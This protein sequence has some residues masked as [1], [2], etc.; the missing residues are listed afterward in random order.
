MKKSVMML[1]L[2]LLLIALSHPLVEGAIRVKVGC[3]VHY[4]VFKDS[5][6]KDIYGTGGIILG[7]FLAYE[8][9]KRLELRGEYNFF[10]TTGKMT[11]SKEKL[12]FTLVPIILG[13]RFKVIDTKLLSPYV[14]IGIGKYYY[15]EDYPER[16][17]DA[18]E[19][20]AGYHAEIGA[21]FKLMAKLQVD[22]N[23]R[24]I[25]ASTNSFDQVVQLGG[26]K[27]G[28]AVGYTF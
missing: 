10:R 24:Y 18:A 17:E 3:S 16:I 22:L 2:F 11:I 15:R 28:I 25:R 26:F 1:F 4:F 23:L 20:R 7:A 9:V 8:P 6:F 13:V 14:G 19:S 5:L 12:I 21:N 27:A